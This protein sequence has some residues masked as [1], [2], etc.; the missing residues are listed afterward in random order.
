MKMADTPPVQLVQFQGSGSDLG[1]DV[2]VMRSSE[3]MPEPYRGPL[4]AGDPGVTA[5]L[6][7][8]S[9]GGNEPFRDFRAW[10]PMD[11]ITIVVNEQSLGQQ[12][13]NTEVKSKSAYLAAIEN[14][15]FIW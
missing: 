10:Q 12:L 1:P 2:R 7:R 11:L 8:E 3:Q 6:W 4:D 13:A 14:F 9:Q 5:S 15:F